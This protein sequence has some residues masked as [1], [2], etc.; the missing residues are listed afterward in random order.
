MDRELW[1]LM[2]GFFATNAGYFMVIPLVSIYATRDLGR[3]AAAAGLVVSVAV[4]V[5]KSLGLSAGLLA[6]RLG[7]RRM[8]LAGLLVRVAGL[9]AFVPARGLGGLLLA[10]VLVGLGGAAFGPPIRAGL[11]ARATPQNRQTL[12]VGRS[13]ANDLGATLGPLLGAG[14]ALYDARL[15]FVASAAAHGLLAA[16]VWRWVRTL[17]TEQGEARPTVRRLLRTLAADR[18]LWRFAALAVLF[19]VLYSQLTLTLPLRAGQLAGPA[20]AGAAAASLF[21]VNAVSAIAMQAAWIPASTRVGAGTAFGLG[22]L[23]CAA[24]I[25]GAGLAPSLPLLYAA[26]VVFTAGEILAFP[27]A[28]TLVADL[29]P[30]SGLASYYGVFNLAWAAGAALGGVLGGWAI[31]GAAATGAAATGAAATGAA[32]TGA[33]AT[34]AAATG[35]AGGPDARTIAVWLAFLAAGV[36]VAAVSRGT[37]WAARP[38]A[39]RTAGAAPEPTE[40]VTRPA[41]GAATEP[42][43]NA[44]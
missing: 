7:R 22:A 30:P 31:S 19:T 20:A 12:F 35:A 39:E 23:L 29:A 25:V 24:G 38:T 34:G 13:L 32:A 15:A 18:L 14:L 37:R 33:A 4:A 9:L 16:A 44:A 3:S 1:V 17:G 8:L 42:A 40:P 10:A 21:T 6:D 11:A 27:A 28:D 2:A 5:Q 36:V 26:V 41:A 43:R